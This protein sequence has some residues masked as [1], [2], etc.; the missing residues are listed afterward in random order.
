MG[1]VPLEMVWHELLT[2]VSVA[3]IEWALAKIDSLRSIGL[4]FGAGFKYF[5]FY[6]DDFEVGSMYIKPGQKINSVLVSSSFVTI[7]E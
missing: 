5:E 2:A 6:C 4:R 3:S 7:H 1:M